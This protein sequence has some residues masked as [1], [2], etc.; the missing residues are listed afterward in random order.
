MKRNIGTKD[1]LLR[2]TIAILLLA[3]AYYYHSWILLLASAFT[4]FEALASWCILYS[5]LGLNSCPRR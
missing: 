4:F 3:L 5:L 1:R 2:L